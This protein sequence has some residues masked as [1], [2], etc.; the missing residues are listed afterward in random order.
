MSDK[1][2]FCNKQ[3][4]VRYWC[5]CGEYHQECPNHIRNHKQHSSNNCYW[6]V[7]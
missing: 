6:E 4:R 5:K 1:C 2:D 7:D 3:S